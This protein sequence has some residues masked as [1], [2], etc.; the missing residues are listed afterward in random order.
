MRLPLLGPGLGHGKGGWRLL[1]ATHRKTGRRFYGF[2]WVWQW[3]ATRALV[4]Q[5][6]FKGEPEDWADDYSADPSKQW[7]GFTFE[8]NPWKGI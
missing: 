3:S 8:V 7:K 5:L 6:G 1:L 2:Y 4:V